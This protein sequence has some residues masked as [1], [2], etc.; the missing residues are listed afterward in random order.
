MKRIIKTVLISLVCLVLAVAIVL[1]G[2]TFLFY[3][4]YNNNK[5]TVEIQVKNNGQIKMMS[6]NLRCISPTDWGKKA[7]FYRANLVIDDIENEKPGII[8]FQEST[9]WHYKYLVDTLKG[10]DSVIEYRDEAFN[11]EG[12][13]IFYNTSLYELVDKGSFW[14]SETPEV[15][16][17]SWGAQ[18]NRVC[19]YVILTDKVSGEDFVVF[20]TH[21]S[22]VSDEARINGI[23]VVL[24]KIAEF[25]SLPSVI[26]GDFN[27]LEGSVTYNSVTENFL[28][29]KKVAEKTSDSHTYQ[30]WGNPEKFQRIDYFMVSK[31]GFKINSYDVLSA[32]HD[33]VYSSDH[34][35][36]VL[37]VE[38]EK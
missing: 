23:K 36:I 31:T 34:C 11:S 38:I 1:V 30:N 37:E 10:Y 27:A 21:L 26:M 5:E 25:G 28:D 20:N 4:Y 9:K 35:P 18:Y 3:P 14:L 6:Y 2:N 24:D 12:C 19:S 32:V 8:G 22:H 33:G 13:P 29:A 17:K 15:M 7:W 16:S